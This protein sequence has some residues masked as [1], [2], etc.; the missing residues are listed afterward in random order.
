MRHELIA[1]FHLYPT[2]NCLQTKYVSFEYK[3]FSCGH[4]TQSYHFN[5][6]FEQICTLIN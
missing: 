3:K 2:I 4:D 5:L 6:L 1:D